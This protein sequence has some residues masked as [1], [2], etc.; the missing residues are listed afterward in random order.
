MTT[1][2]KD[3]RFETAHLHSDL[4]GHS[5]RGG[6]A[7]MLSQ[8]AIFILRLVSTAML[9]RLLSPTDFGL[10]AMVV[11]FAAFADIFKDIGLSLATVQ[12]EKLTHHQASNLFWINV[13][14]GCL[15]MAGL[16]ACSPFMAWFYNEPRLLKTGIYLSVTFLFG[17]LTG[18]HAAL[19]KRQMQFGRIA[20]SEVAAVLL[21]VSIAVGLAWLWRGA[22]DAYMALVWMMILRSFAL[23]VLV[24][25][26]CRWMPGGFR[27]HAGTGAMLKFGAGITGFNVV[28]YFARNADNILI[29]RFCG[30]GPLAYYAKA[31]QFLM[32]PIQQ[33]RIPLVSVATPALSALQKNQAGYRRYMHK[34][35][36]FLAFLTM[37][38][39]VYSVVFA[40]YIVLVFFGEQWLEAIPFFAILALL[41]F[42][43]PIA[44]MCGLV[45]TTTGRSGRYFS[46]GMINAAVTVSSFLIGIQWGALG[47]ALAYTIASYAALLPI[48]RFCLSGSP[49]SVRFF[50]Q[51]VSRPALN[52]IAAGLL[53]WYAKRM[54]VSDWRLSASLVLTLGL[55]GLIYA[56]L[57]SLSGTGRCFVR[58]CV[59]DVKTLFLSKS[60]V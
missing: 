9:A 28:N 4:K 51:A 31:Y 14:A 24:C 3:R 36:Q 55:Y 43:Q 12:W 53:L 19:L 21:S 34:L 35:L 22:P 60:R 30:P 33:L 41:G 48:W 56:A 44:G 59:A 38:A 18:Q 6:S 54:F 17:G 27:R 25:V 58:D 5:L 39:M 26:G 7:V 49:V 13:L 52:S 40:D 37:P 16:I 23:M 29:G 57:F 45:L 42:I 2:E 20:V 8:G 10:I 1:A 15:T 46:Y 47:V 50:L 32:L 11:T